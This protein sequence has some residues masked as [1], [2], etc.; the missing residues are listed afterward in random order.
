MVTIIFNHR[1]KSV[2]LF[3]SPINANVAVFHKVTTSCKGPI[4]IVNQYVYDTPKL[5]KNKGINKLLSIDC[6]FQL[7]KMSAYNL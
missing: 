1:T 3:D 5:D 4:K 2:I 7:A 6:S